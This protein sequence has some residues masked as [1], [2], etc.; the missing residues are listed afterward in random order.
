MYLLEIG[1]IINVGK[2]IFK[3]SNFVCFNNYLFIITDPMSFIT[4][5]TIY[6]VFYTIGCFALIYG[7][8]KV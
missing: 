3:N 2:R 8:L 5:I 1:K 7:A 6:F 4:N